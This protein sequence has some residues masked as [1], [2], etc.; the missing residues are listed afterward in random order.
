M[1]YHIFQKKK[2]KNENDSASSTSIASSDHLLIFLLLHLLSN[3][4]RNFVKILHKQS[5]HA[6]VIPLP[7]LPT[8]NYVCVF[9]GGVCVC[10]GGGGGGLLFSHCL[11][12]H[13]ILFFVLVENLINHAYLHLFFLCLNK[14]C[15]LS[16]VVQN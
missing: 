3:F 2:K 12:I 11:S 16:P 7:P 5:P 15:F 13:N 9:V 10:G 6:L 1:S 4:W 14:T 8:P